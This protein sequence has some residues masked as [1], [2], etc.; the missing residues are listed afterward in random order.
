MFHNHRGKLDQFIP[1]GTKVNFIFDEQS[2]K[3]KILSAWEEYISRREEEVRRLYGER[4]RF[5][6]DTEF[7]PLQAADFWAWWIRRWYVK[8]V[9]PEERIQSLDFGIWQ[10]KRK[11]LPRIHISFNEDQIVQDLSKWFVQ[12]WV[13]RKL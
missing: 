7:L 4:P 13:Q 10:A 8:S 11:D 12:S 3:R 6:D 1:S 2:E 5:E 9:D